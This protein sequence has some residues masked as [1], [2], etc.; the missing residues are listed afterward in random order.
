MREQVAQLIVDL[1]LERCHEV[2]ICSLRLIA[3]KETRVQKIGQLKKQLFRSFCSQTIQVIVD[4][5]WRLR[6]GSQVSPAD[7]AKFVRVLVS[8]TKPVKPVLSGLTGQSNRFLQS[9]TKKVK[10]LWLQQ[11]LIH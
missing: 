6:R 7:Q 11:V 2:N 9:G 5:Q 10:L 1:Q 3:A 8:R 4:D